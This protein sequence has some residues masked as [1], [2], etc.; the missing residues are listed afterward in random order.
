MNAFTSFMETMDR[1]YQGMLEQAN[2]QQQATAGTKY[3]SRARAR[4]RQTRDEPSWVPGALARVKL[5]PGQKQLV[6]Q[7]WDRR[8]REQLLLSCSRRRVHDAMLAD[9]FF[10][11]TSAHS[12]RCLSWKSCMW[13][14]RR[15]A[16]LTRSV[17]VP[18]SVGTPQP[19][20]GPPK[21]VGTFSS[22]T[23][24]FVFFALFGAIA[25]VLFGA[26]GPHAFLDAQGP[27][28]L[29]QRPVAPAPPRRPHLAELRFS[30]SCGLRCVACPCSS[31]TAAAS[32][33]FLFFLG[34][35]PPF[36]LKPS[37]GEPVPRQGRG[38]SEQYHGQRLWQV[39]CA[40]L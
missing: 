38:E 7:A 28:E 24:G 3:R 17:S 19:G 37:G 33:C 4:R 29:L 16:S 39:P 10:S 1:R 23:L 27:L 36:D 32:W 21:P 40:V 6:T 18:G 20:R 8:R 9:H 22:V 31:A 35:P 2:Q 34:R 5:K 15:W 13:W 14:Q 11:T 12:T 26:D 25:P 30:P